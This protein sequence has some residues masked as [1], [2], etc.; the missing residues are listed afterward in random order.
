MLDLLQAIHDR[1][2]AI[3]RA[4]VTLD[5]ER[6]TLQS[7]LGELQI[8]ENVGVRLSKGASH[9]RAAPPK[10]KRRVARKGRRRTNPKSPTRPAGIPQTAA[11]IREALADAASRGLPGLRPEEIRDFIRAKWWPGV[12]VDSVAPTAWRMA[13]KEGRL[14]KEGSLYSLLKNEA[15]A[16][17]TA[18]ASRSGP[19]VNG[20]A[21]QPAP[22]DT[23]RAEAR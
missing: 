20:A 17:P 18:G 13:T 6:A 9:P 10:E 15:P 21:H 22:G 5:E 8:A 4:L 7:E 16:E 23:G 1:R 19:A 12:H 3:E 2:A 14:R 11:M